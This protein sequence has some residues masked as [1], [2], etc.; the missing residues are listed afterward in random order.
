MIWLALWFAATIDVTFILLIVAVY[1]YCYATEDYNW[2]WVDKLRGDR[3]WLWIWW[4]NGVIRE[5]DGKYYQ[6]RIDDFEIVKRVGVKS[7]KWDFGPATL[8][9]KSLGWDSSLPVYRGGA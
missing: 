8:N 3:R 1:T 2:V 6:V 7:Q 9:G 5:I 4:S